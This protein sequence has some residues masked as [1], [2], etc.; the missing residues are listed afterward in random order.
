MSDTAKLSGVLPVVQTPYFEDESI[1]FDTL[2]REI[3]WLLT[4]G[5]SGVVM[6]MVSETLR[7][8]TI[9]RRQ[10]AEHVCQ[11]AAGR[12]AAVISVGA[13]S[14]HAATALARHAEQCGATA[15]MAIPPIATAA[16][17]DEL[18]EYYRA[19]LRAVQIPVIVQDASGYVGRP[20]PIVTQAQLF[21]EFGPERVMFKP[22]A[23]P[24]GPNLTALRE[25]THGRA[26]VFE[27]SGGVALVDSYHRGI[28]GTMPGAELIRAMVALWQALVRGKESNIYRLSLPIGAL[29]QLQTGLDGFLAVEKYLLVKQGIF[30]NTVVR[31]PVAFRLDEETR[32]EV[33]RLFELVCE[34]VSE[35]ATA[36]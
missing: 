31:G 18:L 34:A 2:H 14:R 1:D 15:L 33:D 6:A 7:L 26:R 21:D 29:V 24:L 20:L 27:G 5:A 8:S 3:D 17:T 11:A 19:L 22:E 16:L 23:A 25:A 28:V 4:A 36:S 30:K 10:M 9:E 35:T 12:G 13:E 32:R